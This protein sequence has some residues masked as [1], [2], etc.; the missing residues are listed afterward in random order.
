METADNH[1]LSTNSKI[2]SSKSYIGKTQRYIKTQT[3]ESILQ[4]Y[5]RS[6]SQDVS[7]APTATGMKQEDTPELMRSL[8]TL[9]IGVE[10]VTINMRSK[11]GSIVD[12]V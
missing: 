12:D 8:N 4:T 1:M 6:L 5:G 11:L 9:Q 10:N 3:Q 7:F 2:S